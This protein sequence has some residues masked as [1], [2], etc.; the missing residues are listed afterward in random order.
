MKSRVTTIIFL[1]FIVFASQAQMRKWTLQECVEYAVE[2]N[3]TVE[4]FELDLENAKLDQSDALGNILPDLNGSVSASSNT[5][6]TIVSTTNAPAGTAGNSTTFNM[7][8]GI[9]T[10]VDIF[11]GLRNIKQLQRAK[12][13]AI[14]SQYRVDNLKDDIKLNVAN[15][16]LQVL[17]SKEQLKVFRAQYAVTEQD[18]KRTKELVESGVLP[19][20]DLLEIEATAAN[21][22]QQIV[23]GEGAVL[24]SRV[25]L[26]QLLQITDYENFD[27]ADEEFQIPPSDILKNSAK[28]I[29]DK[30]LT[31]RNDIKFSESNVEIAEKDVEIAKGAYFPTLSGFF[32]YGTRYSDAT[33]LPDGSGGTYKPSFNDQLWIFDGISFGAT[34]NVP[35]FNGWSA[36]NN[37]KRSKIDLEKAKLQL[38][39]DKLDLES[40]IQQAY[41]DVSTFEKAYEAAVKTLEARRLAYDYAKERYDVG[42]MNAFDFSQAQARVDNAEADVI[43]TKYDYIFRLKILEF[44]F[45]IPIS[46]N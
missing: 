7:N 29:F 25:S 17:S 10:N 22:E 19:R 38:E 45:G 18:L 37:V 6:F 39:Q 4:Q 21:Q 16:Y 33:E 43:R 42:L 12:L 41:V 11:R 2:N 44:Y 36:K 5:G 26:A 23:N 24:I 3:L 32:Q 1:L 15:A 28:V 30:A 46:L 9:S 14:A 13:N 31:F 8:G 34:L 27:I 35:I 40:N 20:G